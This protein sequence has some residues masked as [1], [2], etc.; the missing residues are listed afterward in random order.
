V[1]VGLM[2]QWQ[3]EQ[4]ERAMRWVCETCLGS[5]ILD[6]NDGEHSGEVTCFECDGTGRKRRL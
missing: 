5:G 1:A 6:H 3:I 2:K 4:D